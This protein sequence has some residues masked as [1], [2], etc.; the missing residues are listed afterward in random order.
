[1][2]P[3]VSR[4][5]T[6]VLALVVGVATF[7]SAQKAMNQADAVTATFTITAID[8]GSRIVT[9]KD[10]D[11]NTHDMV[12]GPE[13]Q[14]FNALKVGDTVSF[15][16]YESVAT[17]IRRSSGDAPAASGNAGVTRTPGAKPGGTIA[18]QLT[19]TVTIEAIDPKIP[20]VTVK[21]ADGNKLSFK[22]Q[23]KKNIEGYKPG[24]KVD[25]TYTQ[26]L[27]ISVTEPK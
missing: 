12:C 9:L 8:S 11:G 25:V 7:A 22:V 2:K 23:D 3:T 16:Y 24:D 4:I 6:L 18:Q 20:S 5:C 1:M 19:T 13:V 10:K 14:R 15:R 17:A 21:T 26:A 27:A